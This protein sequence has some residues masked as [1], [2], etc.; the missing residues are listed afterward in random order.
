MSK[1]WQFGGVNLGME[2]SGAEE[3]PDH[4]LQKIAILGDFSG[5]GSRPNMAQRTTGAFRPLLIDRDNFD[6]VLAHLNVQLAG[7]P[8]KPNR[9]RGTVSLGALDDFHPDFLLQQVPELRH[10]RE[11]R[12]RLADRATF[13]QAMAEAREDLQPPSE[14]VPPPASPTSDL[15]PAD[16]PAAPTGTSLLEQMLSTG[17]SQESS[18]QQPARRSNEVERFAQAVMAQYTVPADDP[19]QDAWLDAADSATSFALQQLLQDPAFRALEARWRSVDWLTRRIDSD[20]A[21]KV[22]LV[23][24]SEQELRDDFANYDL[25]EGALYE[26][27][28]TR[29]KQKPGDPGW[30]VIVVDLPLDAS[31]D[32]VEL[33]GRLCQLAADAGARLLVGLT[34]AAVGCVD[35]SE[36]FVPAELQQP[37]GAWHALQQLPEASRAAAVWPGYLIRQPYG[38]KTNEV[39]SV[40]FE[41]LAGQEPSAGLLW[42][43]SVYLAVDAWLRSG[44]QAVDVAGLPCVV[45]PDSSGSKQMIPVSRWWLREGMLAHLTSLHVTPVFALPHAGAVRVFPLQNLLGEAL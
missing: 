17:E 6:Q 14:A 9:Q 22:A 41:E 13:A 31:R 40:E 42:G 44:G 1:S 5:R 38:K 18:S 24:I 2:P 7:V 8:V 34:D 19:R 12:R 35:A 33:L 20:V 43:N 37:N 11:L 39:E 15:A 3:V 27:L 30:Q 25:S 23:D 21:T 45:L 29:P 26:L 28:V 16:R 36:P 4:R 32:D 10:L